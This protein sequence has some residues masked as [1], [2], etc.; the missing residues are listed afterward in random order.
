M[1]TDLKKRVNPQCTE[2]AMKVT[3]HLNKSSVKSD[4]KTRFYANEEL[5]R[6][7]YDIAN[8]KAGVKN[9]VLKLILEEIQKWDQNSKCYQF[10]ATMIHEEFEK[11]FHSLRQEFGDVARLVKIEN[12]PDENS[13]GTR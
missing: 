8:T 12:E 2:M 10:I 4:I 13:K 11:K 3:Q 6:P 5:R 7:K 1:K 9:H